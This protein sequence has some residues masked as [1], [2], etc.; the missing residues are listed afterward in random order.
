MTSI[1]SSVSKM[2]SIRI[3]WLGSGNG[4][5]GNKGNEGLHD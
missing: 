2:S 1:S 5:K 4:K 3:S